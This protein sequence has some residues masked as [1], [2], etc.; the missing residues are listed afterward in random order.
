[1]I[2]SYGCGKE[3]THQ[4]K[5]GKWCCSFTYV[6]CPEIIKKNSKSNIGQK[7][8]FK[9]R[10]KCSI[11]VESHKL[12]DYGCNNLAKYKF[13]TGKLCCSK[14]HQSCPSN[15]IKLKDY[16]FKRKPWSIDI[17]NQQSLYML[18]GGSLKAHIKRHGK[19]TDEKDL[20]FLEIYRKR[21]LHFTNISAK[22][23]F[24]SIELKQ[25]GQKKEKNHK[26]IDH[27]F[28]IIEGF[29]LGI[30]PQIISCKSNIRL[31][32]CEQNYSK[33][34]KSDCTLDELFNNYQ[35]EILD[36]T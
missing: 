5:N 33:N 15:K 35:N 25:I 34:G 22:E 36:R 9:K 20:S 23:K 16:S 28:S 4:F 6:K 10:E 2:C 19:I 17:R 29:R 7:R 31:I 21:V 8:V 11:S 12:C 30:L 32:P 13:K 1:M 24:S 14:F 26:N 18:N 3:A 27:I